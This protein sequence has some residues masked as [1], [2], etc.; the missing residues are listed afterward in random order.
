MEDMG[1]FMMTCPVKN[2][3][4]CQVHHDNYVISMYSDV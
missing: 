3:E 1:T 2:V 4:D